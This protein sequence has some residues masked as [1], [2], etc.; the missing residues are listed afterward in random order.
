[1]SFESYYWKKKL[2]KDVAFI[3]KQTKINM[4][5]LNENELDE[6]ISEVKIKLFIIAYSLRKL[7]D[8]NK[9]SDHFSEKLLTAVRYSKNESK[10]NSRN[11]FF[12][13][14]HYNLDSPQQ[15][16]LK[17]RK[18]C[19]QLIHSY[20]F[21][22]C[23]NKGQLHS[24]LFNSDNSKHLF[25]DEIDIKDFLDIVLEFSENYPSEIHMVY[26]KETEDY[27]TTCS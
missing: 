16:T 3:L 2:K 26:C 20:I 14:R 6:V 23:R 12:F 17:I 24:I 10:I 22:L 11:K 18:A 21:E 19:N 25:L 9:V 1:M 27:K 7:I 5:E 15:G 13:E 8:E 4:S